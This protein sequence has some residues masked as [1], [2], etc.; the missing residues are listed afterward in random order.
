MAGKNSDN[1]AQD[2]HPDDN[3]RDLRDRLTKETLAHVPFDGW[4]KQAL[5]MGADDIG[6]AHDEA[7]R[8]FPDLPKD[9]ISWH[10]MMADRAMVAEMQKLDLATMRVTEK[11]RRAIILRLTQN[12]DDR[13]A[14]KKGLAF[15]A[16]PGNSIL[17]SRLLYRTVDDIWFVAGDTATDWNFYSKR[18]LLAGV[19]SSTVLFWLADH[20][21][22]F[23]DTF[24]FMDR[25]LADV[26]KIPK[27]TGKLG[28]AMCFLPRRV[29]AMRS[30]R[31][32]ARAGSAG[33]SRFAR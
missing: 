7:L 5:L 18:A 15:L 28:S 31:A 4:G 2:T 27:V 6:V 14:I 10:S 12:A 3:I 1:P 30:F 23:K 20:S 21:E 24:A 29:K 25:R 13:E 11:V 17:A 19:Y 22:G 8:V 33:G 32:G 16:M 9:M 26:M